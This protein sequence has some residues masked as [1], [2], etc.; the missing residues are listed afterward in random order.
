MTSNTAF[1]VVINLF[2]VSNKN[3]S[4]RCEISSKSTVRIPE[5]HQ[6]HYCGVFN[7]CFEQIHNIS[8]SV[9]FGILSRQKPA[10][11]FNLHTNSKPNKTCGVKFLIAIS[12][13]PEPFTAKIDYPFP[14]PKK[15]IHPPLLQNC[16]NAF[17]LL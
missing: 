10:G 5:Y 13:S 2:K 7:V 3:I 4:T 1:Q 11:S 15:I 16:W 12:K 8:F 17:T 6:W 14:H 9:L